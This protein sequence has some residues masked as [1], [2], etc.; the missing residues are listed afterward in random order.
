MVKAYILK[1]MEILEKTRRAKCGEIWKG[2]N[3]KDKNEDVMVGCIY[4]DG[5][6]DIIVLKIGLKGFLNHYE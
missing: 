1:I 3:P 5:T 4:T 2:G 6:T